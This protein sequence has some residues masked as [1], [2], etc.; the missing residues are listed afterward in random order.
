MS[1][2]MLFCDLSVK[3]QVR[4]ALWTR[5]R[6][7]GA[8]GRYAAATAPE[9]EA[10]VL[11]FL[12][13]NDAPFLTAAALAAP[14]WEEG[15]I[16]HMPNH[17][18]SLEREWLRKVFNINRVHMVNPTVARALSIESLDAGDYEV[19][20]AGENDPDQAK[21]I[22]GTGPGLGMAML[23]QDHY[24]E[25][26]AFS[27]AGG[28]NDLIIITEREWNVYQALA[29]K[30]GRVSTERVVSLN[31]LSEIWQALAPD[32]NQAPAS[33]E[34]IA[35]MA[36]QGDAR[37]REAVDLCLTWLARAASDMALMLGAR[38]GVYLT[39]ELMELLDSLLDRDRFRDT[40]C[41]KGRLTRYLE[42]VPIYIIKSHEC[43]F[44][45]LATLFA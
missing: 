33:A 35:A 11:E 28:H 16:Q 17:G 18:Y 9:F 31:G 45:G 6:G 34:T 3:G 14:G 1:E 10:A 24:G 44:K 4:A 32:A 23:I 12:E 21:C 30:F 41:Y 15:G 27:G 39:G 43:E 7:L 20:N 40:F 13:Q 42:A 25:W 22:V 29:A 19:L 8:Q 26:T 37:A 38:G 5:G 2:T 36:K